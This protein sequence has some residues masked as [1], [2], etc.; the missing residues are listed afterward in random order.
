MNIK[1]D[2]DIK[3]RAQRLTEAMGLPL[4]TF[5]NVQLRQFV[6]SEEVRWA[7]PDIP[8]AATQRQMRG[9]VADY[10]AGKN[11]VGPFTS[12]DGAIKALEAWK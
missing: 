7:V 2:A 6:Q 9:A 11:V 12:A 5:I 1:V 4:S 8:N 10:R 3:E